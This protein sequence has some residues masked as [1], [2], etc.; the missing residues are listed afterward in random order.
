MYKAPEW[1]LGEKQYIETFKQVNP[2]PGSYNADKPFGSDAA[3]I[4]IAG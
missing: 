3:S 2:G 1:T 4:T